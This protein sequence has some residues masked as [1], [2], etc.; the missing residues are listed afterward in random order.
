MNSCHLLIRQYYTYQLQKSVG[1][2]FS[3]RI[4]DF[5]VA[6]KFFASSLNFFFSVTLAER[7]HRI[8]QT[9]ERIST[10]THHF[11]CVKNLFLIFISVTLI[12]LH[13]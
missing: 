6:G 8:I 2:S 4:I 10:R 5:Q 7:Q 13:P 3:N 1:F 12:K 9:E 11:P